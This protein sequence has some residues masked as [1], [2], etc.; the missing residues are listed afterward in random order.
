M[1]TIRHVAIISGQDRPGILDDVCTIV[2][3][4]SGRVLDLHSTYAAGYFAMLA[5]YESADSAAPA[6]EAQLQDMTSVSSLEL[7]ICPADAVEKS[8]TR[9]YR[10]IA[11]G[12]DHVGVLRK[13]SHLLRVLSISVEQIETHSDAEGPPALVLTLGVSRDC[14]LS[15]LREFVG[16]LLSAH[17]M[18]WEIKS[19]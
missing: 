10:L 14:P 11:H 2:E 16:Q 6:V 19:V 15:K 17:K 7:N 3:R 13:L 4:N 1:E 18:D 9:P 12:E 5:V 8:A